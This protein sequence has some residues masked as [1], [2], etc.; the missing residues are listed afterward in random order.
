MFSHVGLPLDSETLEYAWLFEVII[1]DLT[2][3]LS[4]S[5]LQSIIE[6]LQTLVYLVEDPESTLHKPV[7]YELCQH[8]VPQAE[9]PQT[10]RL[11]M[12]CP[13]SDDIKYC[14]TRVSVD[15][16]DIY[17][18]EAGSALNIQVSQSKMINEPDLLFLLQR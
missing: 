8:M 1:G 16:V 18:V 15:A 4:A 11:P 10:V 3:R 12:L 9:C 14:F 2:G 5:Q 13:T 17:L 7:S 6:F